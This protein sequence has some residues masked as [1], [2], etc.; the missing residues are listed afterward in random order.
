MSA[1]SARSHEQRTSSVSET[2]GL[3][4]GPSTNLRMGNPPSTLSVS[5]NERAE[6]RSSEDECMGRL[7]MRDP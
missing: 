6:E 5:V 7:C 1:K 3:T 2:L 4:S